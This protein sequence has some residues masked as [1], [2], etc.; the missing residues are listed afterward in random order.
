MTTSLD[1]AAPPRSRPHAAEHP[2]HRRDIQGLR[3][4]AVL[5]VVLGHAG[6]PGLDGGYVGVD[7]FFVISGFLITGLLLREHRGTGRIALARFYA[8]RAARL[9]PAATLVTVVTLAAAWWWLPPARVPGHGWDALAA[10]GYAVN[11]RLAAVATDYFAAQ[12]A[13][14]FQHFWS[15]AV[16]EQFYLLWPLLLLAVVVRRGGR[17]VTAALAV[18]SLAFGA[19]QLTQSAPWAYF[20][21]P[22]RAWELLA[23]ALLA[24]FAV[25]VPRPVGWLGLAA[26]AAAAVGYDGTTPF[27]GVAALVP[28]LGAA[29]V[30][31]A[32]GP[33]RW[34]ENAPMQ[35]LGRLSYGWYLWHWPLLVVVPAALGRD[36]G[37]A[38]RLGLCAAG[39]LLALAT[40]HW[41]ENPVRH[42]RAVT[43]HPV[44]GLALGAGLSA[45]TAALA[46][47]AVAWPPAVPAGPASA[48]TRDRLLAAA[49]PQAE[50]GRL[51]AA[52]ERT[53]RLPGNLRPALA[54]AAGDKVRPQ[55]DGCH[56]TLNS[57]VREPACT[58]GPADATGTIVLFGDS[59][60]LQWFPA[61]ERYAERHGR[62]LVSL[63]R[64][65]CSPAPVTTVNARLNRPYTECEP[66]RRSALERIRQLRPDLVVVASITNYPGLLTGDPADPR[67][68][69]TDAWDRLLTGLRADAGRVAVMGDT[70]MLGG[71]P[72]DCLSTHGTA[73]DAC[74]EPAGRVLRD[75]QW[76]AA[77]LEAARRAGATVVDPVPWLCA[78]RC[79]L[80]VGDLLVY[81][82]TDHLTSAYAEALHPVLERALP[83][84]P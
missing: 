77:V 44:R 66:W 9:L 49:D 47:L 15:L 46:L 40:Y 29:A 50:L 25:R 84:L 17:W 38:G 69:W 19:W 58:Y 37:T 13:S 2:G 71:D 20:G 8:R 41:L 43:R 70:P 52:A 10:A 36:V 74:L 78:A 76:R 61:L 5:L 39:L 82:D 28:V 4:V 48:S 67:R 14:P 45:G 24:L 3:A 72:L 55:T 1:R 64:S 65:S 11:V 35:W 54:S 18:V 30:I 81:R 21:L 34:L 31:A 42:A 33:A 75:P 79:P 60:A 57:G 59:H 68:V 23:G 12:A 83:A 51:I 80:V 27:P 16:E 56:L 62:R 73:V 53:R 22:G 7:V 26:I 63:T 6:V 32:G